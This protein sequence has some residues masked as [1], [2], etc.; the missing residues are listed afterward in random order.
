V[1]PVQGAQAEMQKID[2]KLATNELIFP[3]PAT[4]AKIHPYVD[5]TATEERQMNDAMQK[6]VGA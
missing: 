3:S 6:V 1:T 4:R 2:P 5:L